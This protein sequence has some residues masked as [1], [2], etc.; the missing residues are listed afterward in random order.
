M[1][2]Y[3]RGVVL[4]NNTILVGEYKVQILYNGANKIHDLKIGQEIFVSWNTRYIKYQ[5]LY[6]AERSAI[7]P[8]GFWFRK[9]KYVPKFK[10][11]SSGH[12]LESKIVR[13]LND[14]GIRAEKST[15]FEDEILGVDLW[16]FLKISSLWQWVPVDVTMQ[17]GPVL[18]KKITDG[19]EK[20]VLVVEVDENIESGEAFMFNF[21]EFLKMYKRK[22]TSFLS[23]RKAKGN[24]KKYH[25][26]IKK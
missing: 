16:V 12:N 3:R 1:Y 23:R 19:I 21:L 2:W 4:D 14:A 18:R 9:S 11:D 22:K 24:E 25:R 6:V 15:P 10:H 17:R 26:C 13:M 20:G 7:E 5:G 8:C